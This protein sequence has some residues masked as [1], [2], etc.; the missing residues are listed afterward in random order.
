MPR[1]F[2]SFEWERLVRFK[3]VNRSYSYIIL[4]FGGAFFGPVNLGSERTAVFLDLDTKHALVTYRSRMPIRTRPC[5][6][7]FIVGR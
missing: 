6:R 7:A 2:V 3:S 5:A 4:L 1:F